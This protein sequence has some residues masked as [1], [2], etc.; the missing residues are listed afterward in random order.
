MTRELHY[1]VEGR[2]VSWQRLTIV[3]G[4][5]FRSVEQRAAKRAHQYA[6]IKAGGG[7]GEVDPVGV[8]AVEVTAYYPDRN[9][10]DADRL[11][12]IPLDALQGLVYANDRQ[13]TEVSCRRRVDRERP[14]MEVAVRRL[15]RAT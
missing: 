2:P 14:R 13:V 10:G 9:Q 12:G 6:A 8:Y 7:R 3:N 15:R 4:R 11:L 1:V 5:P